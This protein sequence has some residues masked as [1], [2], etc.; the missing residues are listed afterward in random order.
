VSWDCPDKIVQTSPSF[1]FKPFSYISALGLGL[2]HGVRKLRVTFFSFLSLVHFPLFFPGTL[3]FPLR[4]C[5][6]DG[7]GFSFGIFDQQ[8]NPR[9]GVETQWNFYGTVFPCDPQ[10][11]TL[12]FHSVPLRLPAGLSVGE[13][14]R[15]FFNSGF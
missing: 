13:V 11:P 2:E 6:M 4:Q 9:R 3:R 14:F 8:Q 5:R 1:G 15:A 10:V 7:A 12:H